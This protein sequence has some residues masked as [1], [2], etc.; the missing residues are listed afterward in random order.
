MVRITYLYLWGN[1]TFMG[2]V[3]FQ[4]TSDNP[5]KNRNQASFKEHSIHLNRYKCGL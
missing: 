3:H 5:D 1:G 2:N 4:E